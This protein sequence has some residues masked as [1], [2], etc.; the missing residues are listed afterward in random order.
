MTTIISNIRP[1]KI[2]RDVQGMW[3]A[4][5]STREIMDFIRQET[6]NLNMGTNSN[7]NRN[8][9]GNKGGSNKGAVSAVSGKDN[10]TSGSNKKTKAF[11]GRCHACHKPGHMKRNCPERQVEAVQE[12]SY[13]MPEETENP[14]LAVPPAIPEP[15]TGA[16]WMG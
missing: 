10:K 8:N 11:G 1:A 7:K 12:Q 9:N 6:L 13:K 3:R 5:K 4:E 16:Q 15:A 2:A 14:L